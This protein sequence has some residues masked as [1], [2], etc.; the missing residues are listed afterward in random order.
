MLKNLEAII[1]PGECSIGT[2]PLGLYIHESLPVVY[3]K[4]VQDIVQ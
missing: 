3:K 1:Q 4:M 2:L